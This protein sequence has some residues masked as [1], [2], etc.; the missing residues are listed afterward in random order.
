MDLNIRDFPEELQKRLKMEA[1]AAGMS[2]R[3]WVVKKLRLY[4]VVEGIDYGDGRDGVRVRRDS[5]RGEG[6]GGVGEAVRGASVTARPS[7]QSGAVDRGGKPNRE[8]QGKNCA[9]HG[10]PMKDFGNAWVCDGPPSHKEFK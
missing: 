10:K 1:V 9:A 6:Q 5:A 8:K 7:N 2:L 4:Q 3:E